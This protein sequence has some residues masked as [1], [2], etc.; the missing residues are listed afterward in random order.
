MDIVL[1]LQHHTKAD[2]QLPAE[3]FEQLMLRPFYGALT[4]LENS[5]VSIKSL[6]FPLHFPDQLDVNFWLAQLNATSGI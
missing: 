1:T 5:L 2:I 3:L 6:F 4:G